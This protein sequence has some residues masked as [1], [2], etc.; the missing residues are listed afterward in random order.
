MELDPSEQN[1]REQ[2]AAATEELLELAAASPEDPDAQA[3]VAVAAVPAGRV[4]LESYMREV[5]TAY[6]V[7]AFGIPHDDAAS[8]QRL[9]EL[10]GPRPQFAWVPRMY[11]QWVALADLNPAL[12]TDRAL[13][14]TAHARLQGWLS[15]A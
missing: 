12:D 10:E 3:L 8:R 5:L 7:C 13:A 2:A 9:V 1:A 11:A 6:G 4:A 15:P 14:G